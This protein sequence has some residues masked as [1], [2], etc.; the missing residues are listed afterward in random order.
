MQIE[1]LLFAAL[2]EAAGRDRITI[3]VSDQPTADDVIQ[4]IADRL[5]SVAALM[6]A[7]RVAVDSSYVGPD[8]LVPP[9]SEVALIPPVSGG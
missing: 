4:A 9:N 6:P 3:D 8:T 2:R 7:C 1:V 5:P